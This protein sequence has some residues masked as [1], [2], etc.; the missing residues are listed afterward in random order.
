MRYF[1]ILVVVLFCKELYPDSTKTSIID[2]GGHQIDHLAI[3]VPDTKKG[4]EWLEQLTGAKAYLVEPEP[5]QWYQSGGLVIGEGVLL[6]II[7]PN[8]QH[9]GFHPIKQILK[10][11]N[12]PNLM[13]YYI[14]VEDF[15]T[16]KKFSKDNNIPLE[17][18]EKMEYLR[19]GKQISYIRSTIGPGFLSE[20]PNIIQWISREERS[21]EDRSCSFKKFWI[22]TSEFEDIKELFST[23]NLSIDV[24][25]R[26]KGGTLN[27]QLRCLNGEIHFEGNSED[28]RGVG[29]FF[30]FLN[31][32]WNYLWNG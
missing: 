20:R 22:R 9:S 5:G 26:K 16:F 12:K 10:N 4:L 15:N 8:P 7:G 32:Y 28:F 30:K 19:N 31:I 2:F 24:T 29:S 25:K 21:N 18:V 13:F 3:G 6:E 27:L 23:L 1:Y 14:A 17:R 11:Y